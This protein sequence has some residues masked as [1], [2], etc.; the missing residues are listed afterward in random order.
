MQVSECKGCGKCW[1]SSDLLTER[2]VWLGLGLAEVRKV[3]RDGDIY[4][5]PQGHTGERCCRWRGPAS[6][7][8][9]REEGGLWVLTGAR[10]GRAGGRG[11]ACGWG[12]RG[13]G[14]VSPCGPQ[15]SGSF[16]SKGTGT[17]RSRGERTLNE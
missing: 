13:Y 2:P 12:R 11:R 1:E 17:L 15:A 4:A 5:E 6:L 9:G 3:A 8:R 16:Y 14:P 7:W 10:W